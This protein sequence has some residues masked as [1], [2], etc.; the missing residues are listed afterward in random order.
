[1]RPSDFFPTGDE[2]FGAGRNL[3]FLSKV[4]HGHLLLRMPVFLFKY[5]MSVRLFYP[6]TVPRDYADQVTNFYCCIVRFHYTSFDSL[7]HALSV[8]CLF[9]VSD[10]KMS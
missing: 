8:S 7:W 10:P 9:I 4:F 5:Q 3:C 6:F 2:C 1:M